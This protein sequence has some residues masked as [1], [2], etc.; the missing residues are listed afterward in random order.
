MPVEKNKDGYIIER[1][2]VGGSVKVTAID[3]KT[4]REVSV[5][6]PKALPKNEASDLAIRK[7]RY[8]QKKAKD[9]K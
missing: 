7:L 6:V 8:M 5:I 1:I 9:K 4:L 3:T 2:T